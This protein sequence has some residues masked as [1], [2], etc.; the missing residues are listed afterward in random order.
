MILKNRN[1]ICVKFFSEN[2]YVMNFSRNRKTPTHLNIFVQLRP[3]SN[4]VRSPV[5]ARTT[6]LGI[7]FKLRHV[8]THARVTSLQ[9]LFD[10]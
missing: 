7:Q 4:A 1:N 8:P 5:R 6:E 10:A 2:F 9:S 3:L